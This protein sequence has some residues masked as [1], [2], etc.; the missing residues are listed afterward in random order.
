MLLDTARNARDLQELTG[1]LAAQVTPAT[2]DRQVPTC[3][4][5]ALRDL[6]GHLG[7]V[8]RWVTAIV[9]RR[10]SAPPARDVGGPPPPPDAP[11]L[12]AWL[13]QGSDSLREA[14]DQ[15]GPEAQVW[16]WSGDDRVAFWARRMANEAAVHAADAQLVTGSVAP[17]DPARAADGIEEWLWMLSLPQGAERS[18][19]YPVRPGGES[20]HVHATDPELSTGS[21]GEWMIRRTAEGI[22]WERG[23]VKADV[24]LRGG[25]S[26]LFLLL[27]RRLD[28]ETAGVE[29]LGDRTLLEEWLDHS[30]FE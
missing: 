20:L 30:R 4:E 2:L 28:P 25:A 15:A 29:V 16:S 19:R 18:A 6:V 26:G 24:A 23:H 9:A 7:Y 12:A 3:P 21:E 8:Q 11:D 27:L 1:L 14:V 13:G 10:L 17:L 5:W 22:S